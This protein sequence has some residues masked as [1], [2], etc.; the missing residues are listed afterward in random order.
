MDI[1]SGYNR[2]EKALLGVYAKKL[3]SIVNLRTLAPG[4]DPGKG[5]AKLFLDRAIAESVKDNTYYLPRGLGEMI[6]SATQMPSSD[7]LV[8]NVIFQVRASLPEKRKDGVKDADVIF[9]WS[10]L[11]VERRLVMNYDELLL[12]H[13]LHEET[14]KGT[15]H[16]EAISKIFKKLPIYAESTNLKSSLIGQRF[17]RPGEDD[18]PLPYELSFRID[19]WLHGSAPKDR[20]ELQRE[21]QQSSSFN[22]FIRKQIRVNRI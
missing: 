6:L 10:M 20:E 8:I 16:E 19:M 1:F 21:L 4:V 15:K 12:N 13:L 5:L 9:W 11:G 14:E 3:Q 17:S 22:A 18:A 7:P 2:T